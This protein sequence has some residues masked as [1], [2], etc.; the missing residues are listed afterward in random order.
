MGPEISDGLDCGRVAGVNDY[1]GGW[2]MGEKEL[3]LDGGDGEGAE[4]RVEF[5]GGDPKGPC[6]VSDFEVVEIADCH[7][8][9]GLEVVLT[10]PV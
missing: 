3:G 6:V 2:R 9:G 7:S 10:V 8:S 5:R 4:V 1:M